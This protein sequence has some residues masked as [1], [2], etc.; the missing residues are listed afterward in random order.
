MIFQTYKNVFLRN[1]HSLGW[2]LWLC[3]Y[4][5]VFS[6]MMILLVNLIFIKNFNFQCCIPLSKYECSHFC[7][8]FLDFLV[9]VMRFM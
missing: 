3:F 1:V 8:L 7:F 6:N 4:R 5:K 9:Q 2:L